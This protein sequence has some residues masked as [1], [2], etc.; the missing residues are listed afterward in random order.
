MRGIENFLYRV[1]RA[2]AYVAKDDPECG[3]RQR[4]SGLCVI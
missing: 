2:G 1:Q 4:S 3:E